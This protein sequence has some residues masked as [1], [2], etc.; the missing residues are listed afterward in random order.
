[1]SSITPTPPAATLRRATPG[2]AVALAELAAR[3]FRETYAPPAGP[4]DPADV[5]AYVADHFG[6]ALQGAEL[7]D[8]RLR[9][10]VAESGGALAG[11]AVVRTASR[12]GEA[13]N[14]APASEQEATALLEVATAEL[15]RLYVD[16]PWHGSGVAARLLDAARAEAAAAGAGA[17][18]FSVY[19]R[20]PRAVAFYRKRGARTIATATFTMGREVQHDWLMAVPTTSG[21]AT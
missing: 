12:P 20:N 17:L 19:Q 11:Y 6:P 5:E 2:D 8:A 3:T 16:R 18:W 13:D 9:V 14:F 15:A 4:C 1:M 21:G 7:A 10:V